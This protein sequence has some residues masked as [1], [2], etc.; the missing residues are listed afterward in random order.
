MV[1]RKVALCAGL[2]SYIC[3]WIFV[4]CPSCPAVSFG[5]GIIGKELML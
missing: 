1:G 2:M 5:C 3:P 4:F